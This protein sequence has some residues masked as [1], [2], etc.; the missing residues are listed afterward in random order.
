ME[1]NFDLKP[2]A[3]SRPNEFGGE[4]YIE[5]KDDKRYNIA[6]QSRAS[7]PDTYQLQ[8]SQALVSLFHD[9][10]KSLPEIVTGLNA[11]GI[12]LPAGEDWTE[13]NFKSEMQRLGA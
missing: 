6:W 10:A 1:Y 3:K 4:G 8:L 2:W 7:A 9:G 12:S 5:S 13:E 11:L